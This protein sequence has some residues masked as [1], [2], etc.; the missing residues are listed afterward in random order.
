MDVEGG[1]GRRCPARRSWQSLGN[2]NRGMKTVV[3][4]RRDGLPNSVPLFL[5]LGMNPFPWDASWRK[6]CIESE[7][8]TTSMTRE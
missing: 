7:S 5:S 4:S 8:V 6:G 3:Q 1:A 2:R